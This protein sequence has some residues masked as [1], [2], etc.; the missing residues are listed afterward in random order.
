ML[1]RGTKNWL[2]K[3]FLFVL[4]YT[5]QPPSTASMPKIPKVGMVPSSTRPMTRRSE[6]S[7]WHPMDTPVERRILLSRRQPIL[8]KSRTEL[9]GVGGDLERL[10]SQL[11]TSSK[12]MWIALSL[13]HTCLS[14]IKG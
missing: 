12:N 2:L 6:S 7:M 1:L 3:Q 11:R 9:L 5:T 4:T 10:F 14:R 8:Q 13:T